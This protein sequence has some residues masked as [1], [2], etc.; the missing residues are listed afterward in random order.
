MC[1]KF[2][3]AIA[4]ALAAFSLAMI[5]IIGAALAYADVVVIR[6]TVTAHGFTIVGFLKGHTK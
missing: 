1:C 2:M 4:Y 3:D 6:E 5:L